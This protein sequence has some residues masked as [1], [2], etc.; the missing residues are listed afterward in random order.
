MAIRVEDH[1]QDQLIKISGSNLF[2][3]LV[4]IRFIAEKP[5]STGAFKHGSTEDISRILDISLQNKNLLKYNS[6]VSVPLKRY[7]SETKIVFSNNFM[8]Y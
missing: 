6:Y 3:I 5:P 4:F 8:E 7:F 2:Q 1:H